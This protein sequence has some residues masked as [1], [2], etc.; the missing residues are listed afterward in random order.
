M[1]ARAFEAGAACGG[2]LCQGC[3]IT[4]AQTSV[5]ELRPC[6]NPSCAI[7]IASLGEMGKGEDA[8]QVFAAAQH[9]TACDLHR[10][11]PA[12]LLD[13]TD[14]IHQGEHG[15]QGDPQSVDLRGLMRR[16]I[17]VGEAA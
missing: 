3:G 14:E 16:Q 5:P 4:G 9:L 17:E 12:G 10:H 6:R 2:Y 7:A 11:G 13:M 15:R 1:A 8:P